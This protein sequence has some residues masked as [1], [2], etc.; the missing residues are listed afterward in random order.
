MRKTKGSIKGRN[1]PTSKVK[2]LQTIFFFVPLLLNLNF[3]NCIL[4][5]NGELISM[6]LM[7][8]HSGSDT[9]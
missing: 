9:W 2:C 5:L 7:K 1:P 8:V 6:W 3:Y 4:S